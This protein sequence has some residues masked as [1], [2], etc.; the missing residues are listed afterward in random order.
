MRQWDRFPSVDPYRYIP[1]VEDDDPFILF[2]KCDTAK[3]TDRP[4]HVFVGPAVFQNVSKKIS[5]ARGHL[6]VHPCNGLSRAWPHHIHVA[7]NSGVTLNLSC[8]DHDPISSHQT[9]IYLNIASTF[10]ILL[11]RFLPY[12]ADQFIRCTS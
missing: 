12:L 11:T 1:V 2:V 6:P 7:S 8:H 3:G 10:D 4:L 9:F 5:Y